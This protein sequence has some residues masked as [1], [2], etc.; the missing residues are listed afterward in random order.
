MAEYVEV[1]EAGPGWTKVKD[2]E[3][4]VLTV[5]GNRNW[6]NNNPGNIEY[7]AFARSMGAI[8]TDGRFAVFPSYDAGRSAK[9]SL[10][11][12]SPNYR[13]RSISSAINR[14][15]PPFENNTNAYTSAVAASI[16]VDPSTPLSSLNA[17]QR[18]TM[19]DAMQ[20]VE[21]WKVGTINGTPGTEMAFAPPTSAAPT[22]AAGML[23]GFANSAIGGIGGLVAGGRNALMGQP[24]QLPEGP[25]MANWLTA[26]MSLPQKI[27]LGMAIKRA[28][29]RVASSSGPRGIG[30]L[31]FT[32]QV[33]NADRAL[34]A[35]NQ[36][37]PEHRQAVQKGR[38][39]FVSTGGQV[40]PTRAMNGRVRRS[41][42]DGG[43]SSNGSLVG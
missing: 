41:Y 38:S 2:A 21:G 30:G 14:Y 3:G 13:D 25:Q 20:R 23:G 33:N 1:V 37:L 40:M 26:G 11:F 43:G 19:L 31:G 8:G 10:L 15:A 6:R 7:G 35:S 22:S 24:V 29:P 32:T 18:R 12:E 42:G 28:T 27:G 4:N 36:V 17:Q 9:E 39:S 34:L 5:K 16:G